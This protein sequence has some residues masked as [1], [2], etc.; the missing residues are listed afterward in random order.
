MTDEERAAIEREIEA[1]EIV[2][3]GLVESD[4]FLLEWAREKHPEYGWVAI[5]EWKD[6]LRMLREKLEDG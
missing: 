6:H 1:T 5:Q 3:E 2:L 4:D